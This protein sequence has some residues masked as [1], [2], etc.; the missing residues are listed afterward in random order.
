MR[1]VAIVDLVG[2]FGLTTATMTSPPPRA[3]GPGAMPARGQWAACVQVVGP[4]TMASLVV[5]M[6]ASNSD[7]SCCGT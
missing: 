6:M 7:R 2:F 1:R 5:W 4:T 3:T